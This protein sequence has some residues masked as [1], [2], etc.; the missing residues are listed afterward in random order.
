MVTESRLR[1]YPAAILL[2]LLIGV[3]A[4]AASAADRGEAYGGDYPAFYGAGEIAARGD[5]DDLYDIDRQIAAQR[6][7]SPSEDEATARYFAYPPQVAFLYQPLA[8]LDYFPSYLAHTALMALCLWGSLMLAR[9][10]VVWLQGRVVLALAGAMV[11][12]PMFRT[13]TGGSNT[14]LTLLLIV[15]AWRLVHDD[16][17]LLAGIVLAGLSYKPQFLVPLV[18]LF[19]LGRYWRVVG[20]AAVGAAGFYVWG[21]LLRGSGWLSEWLDVAAEFGRIDAELNGHS[22]ISFI[23]FAENLFGVGMSAPVALAWMLAAATVLFLSWLWWRSAGSDLDPL[24]AVTMPG[25][26]LL[27]LH[28]MSHDGAVVV[29][30]AGVGIGAWQRS[31]W[32]PWVAAIWLL[33]ASQILIKRLGWSPG[34]LMLLVAL[35]WGWLLLAGNRPRSGSPVS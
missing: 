16:R 1:T 17:Q 5:W 22:A 34:L 15:A 24:L 3:V 9:P 4:G 13:V 23:G 27:S 29:L 19:L 12:W 11:F 21:V 20:G 31:R 18:G 2:A 7:L 14:A 6:V 8:S 32:L 30:T 26:L 35:A 10:M 33:G 28:A 25:I